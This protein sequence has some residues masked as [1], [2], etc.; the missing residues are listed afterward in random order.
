MN[1]TIYK[2]LFSEFI[3]YFATVLFALAAIVWT[4]QAVNYL[5]LITEDGH[6]FAIY[7]SYSFLTISKV[8]TKLIPFC[9]LLATVLTILKLEKD[10]ELI[11]LWTSGLNK[12]HI[13]NHLISISLFIMFVQLLLTT[14]IN[15]TMLN[16]SRTLL[17][18]SELKF[19]S[20]IFKEKQFND[21]VEGLTI[22]ID[23][24]KMDNTY[25]NIFIRDESTVLSSVGT[26]SSTIFA[27]SGYITNDEKYLIL[28]NGNI[29]K[30]NYEG[31]INVVSF[32]KTSFNL[33]GI[34]TKSISEP[35]MQETSSLKILSC[36]RGKFEENKNMHN[37]NQTEKTRTNLKIEINKR[38]G[39]PIYIPLIALICCFLLGSRKDKKIYSYNK[40]IYSFIGVVFLVL[41]EIT[42]RYSG[43]S[44]KYT[45][46]YYLIPFVMIPIVYFILIKKFKYENL[47]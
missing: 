37:C 4:V 19:V 14:A 32:E 9:F 30:L 46:I 41:A 26:K 11:T 7:F 31:D 38:I 44:W 8:L 29:Q 43:I 15:P 42:V 35:K 5:D 16:L 27:K 20:S 36:M 39:M 22:F 3:R 34:S 2:Y 23:K 18:N 12:I 10:N 28:Q 6:A 24:K 47:F 25:E 40:Y 45:L 21:T 33:S 13:V 17:K 1:K